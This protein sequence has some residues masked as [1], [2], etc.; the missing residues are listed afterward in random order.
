MQKKFK[1][2]TLDEVKTVAGGA[3]PVTMSVSPASLSA[4][5]VSA[6]T[7]KLPAHSSPTKPIFVSAIH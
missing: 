4:T 2:L 7:F 1:E 3:A 5:S 6:G